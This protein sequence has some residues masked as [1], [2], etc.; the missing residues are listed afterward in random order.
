MGRIQL[1]LLNVDGT[2]KVLYGLAGHPSILPAE[3]FQVSPYRPVIR[4]APIADRRA[5]PRIKEGEIRDSA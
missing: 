1:D 4:F 5:T 2:I 3:S